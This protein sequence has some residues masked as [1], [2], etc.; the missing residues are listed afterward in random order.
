M[1]SNTSSSKYGGNTK[2]TM[3]IPESMILE[4]WMKG[5]LENKQLLPAHDRGVA[6][7]II[8]YKNSFRYLI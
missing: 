4:N 8:I 2:N 3:Q 7:N 5:P 6:T 1:R